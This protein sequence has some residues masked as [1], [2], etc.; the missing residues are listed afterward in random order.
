MGSQ[1]DVVYAA[2]PPLNLE[3]PKA[4]PFQLLKGY[5]ELPSEVDSRKQMVLSKETFWR[6]S[7]PIKNAKGTPAATI[8]GTRYLKYLFNKPPIIKRTGKRAVYAFAEAPTF[9][10]PETRCIKF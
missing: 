4:P 10:V 6:Q 2:P 1:A 3:P 7:L 8:K 9:P 5:R